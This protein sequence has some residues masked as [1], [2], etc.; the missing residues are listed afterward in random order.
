[1][2]YANCYILKD[3]ESAGPV[4]RDAYLHPASAKCGI[5]L[6]ILLGAFLLASLTVYLALRGADWGPI[7]VTRL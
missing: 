7:F 5:I 3:E 6:L 2:V 1:M 4:S